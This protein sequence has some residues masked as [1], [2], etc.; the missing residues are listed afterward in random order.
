M[1]SP[2]SEP[3]DCIGKITH[4]VP[5]AEL[6]ISG[7]FES[8]FFLHRENSTYLLV[9][10]NLQFFP[11]CVL[12]RLKEFGGPQKTSDMVGSIGWVHNSK[13]SRED[14]DESNAEMT[15]LQSNGERL[16]GERVRWSDPAFHHA[17]RSAR[18][19]ASRNEM[20]QAACHIA[21]DYFNAITGMKPTNG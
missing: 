21:K 2:R 9:L 7:E 4:E 11:A 18:R 6:A 16:V 12:A 3:F 17:R 1:A 14:A 5:A 10:E 20:R 8:E 13:D 19:F 15:G